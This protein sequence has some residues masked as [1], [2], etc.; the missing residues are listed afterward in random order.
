M[1]CG[2]SRTKAQ[3]CPVGTRSGAG[4]SS[5]KWQR[6]CLAEQGRQRSR[7][8]GDEVQRQSFE[9]GRQRPWRTAARRRGT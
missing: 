3:R 1:S 5:G 7:D 9:L 4:G 6:R 2:S 8:S